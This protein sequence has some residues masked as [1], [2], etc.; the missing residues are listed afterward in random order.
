MGLYFSNH[1]YFLRYNIEQEQKLALETTVLVEQYTVS[2]PC[3][4]LINK[5]FGVYSFRFSSNKAD[6][7]GV[8][9]HRF[10][11]TYL[12]FPAVHVVNVYN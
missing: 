8:L 2:S 3:E 10:C 11:D 5:C 4:A 7:C 9:I 6:T 12:G 1:C